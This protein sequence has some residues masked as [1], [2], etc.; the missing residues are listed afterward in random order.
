VFLTEAVLP[1]SRN[2]TKKILDRQFL[3]ISAAGSFLLRNRY[4]FTLQFVSVLTISNSKPIAV[5]LC[6]TVNVTGEK[7]SL[8]FFFPL[9]PTVFVKRRTR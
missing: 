6:L 7:H 1:S 8:I 4:D 2:E 3:K 9:S 5:A